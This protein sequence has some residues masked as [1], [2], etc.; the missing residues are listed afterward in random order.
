[1]QDNSTINNQP[2]KRAPVPEFYRPTKSEAGPGPEISAIEGGR[3]LESAQL[4]ER[5]E[6]AGG[7]ESAVGA[8]L[9]A[10]VFAEQ[11]Y[12]KL[13]NILA[14][15]LVDIYFKMPPLD[16][17]LFKE[18]GEETAR[19]ILKILAKPKIKI[20][21]IIELIKNWLKF[22]PGVNRFF[23]EQTAKIKTDRIISELGQDKKV[24]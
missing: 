23:L 7:Q 18:K 6:S 2:E 22:I 20:K 16:Q 12:Q 3:A 11:S 24:S 21:K 9:S 4:R 8:A 14:D 19:G 15:D 1:M 10:P 17:Q 13:E 5:A